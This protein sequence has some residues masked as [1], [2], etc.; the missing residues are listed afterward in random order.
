MIHTS[1]FSHCTLYHAH[2]RQKSIPCILYTQ[3]VTMTLTILYFTVNNSHFTLYPVR[4]TAQSKIFPTY[5]IHTKLPCTDVHGKL[6]HVHC[7]QTTVPC[8]LHIACFTPNTAYCKL[9][10]VHCT[11][12]NVPITLHTA[13]YTLYNA[14]SKLYPV[15]CTQET[16][17]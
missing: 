1:Q 13:N 11:R 5:C 14:D 16:V 12:Q 15:Y 6:G 3:N 4:C 17:P 8:A 2:Y 10:P 7:T 9:S